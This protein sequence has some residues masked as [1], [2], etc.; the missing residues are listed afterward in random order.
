MNPG[1]HILRFI[2]ASPAR[3]RAQEGG[4]RDRASAHGDKLWAKGNNN[5]VYD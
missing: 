4:P 1:F 3:A 5:V 2:P